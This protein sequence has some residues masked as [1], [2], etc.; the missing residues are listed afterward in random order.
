MD[1]Q[2]SWP[3][4]EAYLYAYKDDTPVGRVLALHY[5]ASNAGGPDVCAV[6]YFYAGRGFTDITPEPWP[7][8]TVRTLMPAPADYG[9]P[10]LPDA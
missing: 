6:C 2:A 1:N 8:P 10:A 9:S 3:T 5:P 4:G 7:C